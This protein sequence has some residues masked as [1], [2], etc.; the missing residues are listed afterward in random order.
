MNNRQRD[1]EALREQSRKLG[2]TYNEA[3]EFIAKTTGGRDTHIY[4]DTDS[5]MV[6]EKNLQS[7]MNKSN[8]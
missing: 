3:K 6:K 2:L 7:E 5:K 4:S 1:I 8:R